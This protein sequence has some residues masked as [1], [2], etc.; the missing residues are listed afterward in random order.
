LEKAILAWESH[1]S[2][3]AKIRLRVDLFGEKLVGHGPYWEQRSA[4]GLQW[5]WELE[6]Q[7]G[8]D[9]S[10][11]VQVC[12]GDN[13]W[14]F[15]KGA[16]DK[17]GSV[18]RITVSP[19]ADALELAG[20]L[21]QPGKL[22]GWLGLGGFSRLL[23]SLGAAFDF[24]TIELAQLDSV[25]VWRLSGQ[26]KPERLLQMLP[27]QA[28]AIRH[29]QPADPTSLPR[30]LPDAVVMYLGKTNL[31]P[32]KIEYLR[33][34]SNPRYKEESPADTVILTMELFDDGIDGPIDPSRFAYLPGKLDVKDQTDAYLE[35]LHLKKAGEERP[36]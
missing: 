14:V 4:R 1:R 3:S 36:R 32:Y 17:Q 19:V 21:P 22:G 33:R 5:R 12:D 26:W 18:T 15:R 8:N 23:R 10:K 2:L 27:D 34:C 6:M 31:M 16:A 13:F 9:T 25:E 7:V 20:Q 11:L 28:A 29:G 30:H 35:S 24:S